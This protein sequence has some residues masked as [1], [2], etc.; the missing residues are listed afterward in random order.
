MEYGQ[1]TYVGSEDLFFEAGK[2]KAN[3]KHTY[4]LKHFAESYWVVAHLVVNPSKIKVKA[5]SVQELVDMSFAPADQAKDEA[6]P[7]D[8]IDGDLS[9]MSSVETEA[10]KRETLCK[11]C[12]FPK[13][14][15][16]IHLCVWTFKP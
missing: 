16:Q 4:L 7:Q 14:D 9:F 13:K 12:G 1:E 3:E 10:P 6:Q 8:Q 5:L 15:G 11:R 2:V